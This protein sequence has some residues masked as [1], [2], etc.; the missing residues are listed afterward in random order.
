MEKWGGRREMDE[1]GEE[2]DW[3][4]ETRFSGETRNAAQCRR[5]HKYCAYVEQNQ[6]GHGYKH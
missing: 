5:V 2:T 3:L 6:K 1:C 4:D